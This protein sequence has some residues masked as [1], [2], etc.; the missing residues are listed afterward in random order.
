MKQNSKKKKK[1]TSCDKCFDKEANVLIC[2]HRVC[3]DCLFCFACPVCN[4]NVVPFCDFFYPTFKIVGNRIYALLEHENDAVFF[5]DLTVQELSVETYL[6]SNRKV[7]AYL[8]DF[9]DRNIRY[10]CLRM[11]IKSTMNKINMTFCSQTFVDIEN[12][13]V[14]AIECSNFIYFIRDI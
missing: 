8:Q 1:L 10:V 9:T 5:G 13:A 14:F 2:G 3:T 12:R 7:F 11:V 4:H 6:S